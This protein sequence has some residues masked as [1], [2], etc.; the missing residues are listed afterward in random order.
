M[1]KSIGLED[2]QWLGVVG[3]VV[4]EHVAPVIHDA[5][6][7]TGLHVVEHHVF[8][9]V[10]QVRPASQGGARHGADQRMQLSSSV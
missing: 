5:A 10:G 7:A 4:G 2:W 1:P 8:R 9:Q 3:V 6:Q